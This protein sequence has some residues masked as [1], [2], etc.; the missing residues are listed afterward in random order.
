MPSHRLV[1]RLLVAFAAGVCVVGSAAAVTVKSEIVNRSLS[2]DM[3]TN[4]VLRA[5]YSPYV[6][7]NYF[8]TDGLPPTSDKDYE[9]S[10]TTIAQGGYGAGSGA[11]LMS[12]EK[13]TETENGINY[14]SFNGKSLHLKNHFSIYWY[15]TSGQFRFK[16]DGL[17][18]EGNAEVRARCNDA[19]T[20]K[21]VVFSADTTTTVT[22]SKTESSSALIRSTQ[23]NS[24]YITY[25][26]LGP[27]KSESDQILRTAVYSTTV[28]TGGHKNLGT[29]WLDVR[30]VC[31]YKGSFF[32]NANSNKLIIAGADFPGTAKMVGPSFLSFDGTANAAGKVMVTDQT[33][34]TV[35][36][37]VESTNSVVVK[38]FVWGS[39]PMTVAGGATNAI[40]TADGDE[41]P[42]FAA[43][44]GCITVTDSFSKGSA[45]IPV[46]VGSSPDTATLLQASYPVLR[47]KKSA[48]ATALTAADFDFGTNSE[49]SFDDTDPEWYVV[50][51]TPPARPVMHAAVSDEQ[52][53]IRGAS[54]GSYN[55]CFT[56]GWSW[57]DGRV[58]HDDAD[59]VVP[60][61]GVVRTPKDYNPVAGP[62]TFGGKTLTFLQ[63]ATL[64]IATDPAV[65]PR[66]WTSIPDVRFEGGS[67]WNFGCKTGLTNSTLRVQNSTIA[68]PA[69][70]SFGFAD[71]LETEPAI[72]LCNVTLVSGASDCF[73]IYDPNWQTRPSRLWMKWFGTGNSF[74]GTLLLGTNMNCS[75]IGPCTLAGTVRGLGTNMAIRVTGAVTFGNLALAEDAVID[76]QQTESGVSCLTVANE[77][78]SVG[79]V[80][81]KPRLTIGRV[82]ESQA[83]TCLRFKDPESTK[84]LAD[85]FTIDLPSR[86]TAT[87]TDPDASGMRSVVIT[88]VPAGVMLFFR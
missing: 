6:N 80:T 74:L 47:V 39:G 32:I 54:A 40:Q 31:D 29:C 37:T 62:V 53:Q 63:G 41:V 5:A 24:G 78:T 36:L 16:N 57:S 49:L 2:T 70:T 27:L 69:K 28:Q 83:F 71:G 13:K 12:P 82:T 33:K 48:A 67:L 11:A 25:R 38:D 58:P 55:S 64:T 18:L 72:S 84:T 76:C 26:F 8:W 44:F 68:K 34:S 4:G 19:T 17:F 65:K 59:Y 22:N 81:L 88:Y 30:N 79:K 1:S 46:F 73:M 7:G 85:N 75:V 23:K 20:D 51:V 86:C 56:N 66:G 43:S 42:Y 35:T 87:L 14:V 21:V 10:T 61:G 3:F 60:N 77:L 52:V 9:V 45:A 15:A 50:S